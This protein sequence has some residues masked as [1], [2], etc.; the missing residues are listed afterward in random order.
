MK[1]TRPPH[2]HVPADV[3]DRHGR[4]SPDAPA[5]R[6]CHVFDRRAAAPPETDKSSSPIP[7]RRRPSPASRQVAATSLLRREPRPVDHRVYAEEEYDGGTESVGGE[8]AEDGY[9]GDTEP[10]CV[11]AADDG[12]AG[13][14]VFFGAEAQ[15]RSRAPTATP[16]SLDRTSPARVLGRGSA[17]SSRGGCGRPRAQRQQYLSA[18]AASV[19]AR[20]A[21]R[22]HRDRGSPACSRDSADV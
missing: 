14:A 4:P 17:G 16:G 19:C 1:I 13:D 8:A 20:R 15:T 10:L 7:G 3:G 22:E 11:E 2:R 18:Y 12:Y 9:A 6:S 21:G 5:D